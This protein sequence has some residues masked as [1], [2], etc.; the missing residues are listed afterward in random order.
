MC[1]EDRV[2]TIVEKILNTTQDDLYVELCNAC[3]KGD[4]EKVK[5]LLNL[6]NTSLSKNIH[7]NFDQVF[8]ILCKE[9]QIDIINYLVLDYEIALTKYIK[10]YI[11]AYPSIEKIFL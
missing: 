8:R 2:F 7:S 4:L 6:P 3:Q 5:Y 1:S 9:Q 11:T 10:M